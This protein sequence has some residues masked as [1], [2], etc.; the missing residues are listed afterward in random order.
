[1][2]NGQGVNAVNTLNAVQSQ[3]AT[4]MGLNPWHKAMLQN[5]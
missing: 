2:S 5:K 4:V 1:M 3:K